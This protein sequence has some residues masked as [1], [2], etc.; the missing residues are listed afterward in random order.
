M[1]EAMI[2]DLTAAR[3]TPADRD[4]AGAACGFLSGRGQPPE[5]CRLPPSPAVRAA[6]AL[7]KVA[8]VAGEVQDLLKPSQEAA[9]EAGVH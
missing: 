4:H 2:A 6:V 5:L 8:K 1:A 3:S 7:P 9:S